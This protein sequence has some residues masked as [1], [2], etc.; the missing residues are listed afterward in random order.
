MKQRARVQL[1]RRLERLETALD[2]GCDV[3]RDAAPVRI[4]CPGYGP[5]EPESPDWQSPDC[6]ACGKEGIVVVLTFP[7]IGTLEIEPAPHGSSEFADWRRAIAEWDWR[8]ERSPRPVL[9]GS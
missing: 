6:P 2:P 7:I 3:C 8:T 4:V 5:C 9:V 1:S